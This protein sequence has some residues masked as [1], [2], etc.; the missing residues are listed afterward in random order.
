MVVAIDGPA[1]A[2]KSTVAGRL[3][4]ALGYLHLNSGAIYRA[5][6]LLALR[7]G[8]R[9]DDGEGLAAAARR[10]R[11]TFAPSG[12]LYVDSE[13]VSAAVRATAVDEAVAKVAALAAVRKAVTEHQR[14]IAEQ[15]DVVVEGRDVTT[16]VFP[17]APVK[18][19]LDASLTERAR[20]R[21][22]E[23]REKGDLTTMVE[24]RSRMSDR[25]RCDETRAHSPLRVAQDAV[26]VDT[27]GKT[28]EDV[29]DEL[30]RIVRRRAGN[31]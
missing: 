29:V 8:I 7:G 1:G 3:A 4:Q 21:Y 25:D 20:R 15:A 12:A 13:D 18:V 26:V 17:D 23:L 19:Y 31:A 5:V 27:T 30:V 10:A 9:L 14:R 16:V 28:I 24:V 11:V 22:E 2:G 6:A